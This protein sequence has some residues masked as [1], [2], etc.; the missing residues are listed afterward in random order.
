M[1]DPFLFLETAF[2][3]GSFGKAFAKKTEEDSKI[4]VYV[5]VLGCIWSV[6]ILDITFEFDLIVVFEVSIGCLFFFLKTFSS[7]KIFDNSKLGRWSDIEVVMWP[8]A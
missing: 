4:Q 2:I 6:N 5:I 1:Q 8:E 3:G 7:Y